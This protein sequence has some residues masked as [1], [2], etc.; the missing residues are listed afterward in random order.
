MGSCWEQVTM[1]SEMLLT[2]Q[3]CRRQCLYPVPSVHRLFW[4]AQQPLK[5]LARLSELSHE[6]LEQPRAGEGVRVQQHVSEQRGACQPERVLAGIDV[7]IAALKRG[8]ENRIDQILLAL[9][10]AAPSR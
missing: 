10:A 9:H 7:G 8:P 1:G 2:A 3:C 5:V 4:L 6:P